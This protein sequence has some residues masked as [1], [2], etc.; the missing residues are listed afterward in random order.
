M[1]TATFQGHTI[2]SSADTVYLEGNH[3][4]PRK[5]VEPGALEE[6]W[7]RTLCFWKGIARYYHIRING[8]RLPNAAWSYPRPS[9]LARRIR[10]RIAFETAAGIIVREQS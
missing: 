3:Y 5:A 7:V 10:N 9:P 1:I 4:F 2:A 6:S 8:S